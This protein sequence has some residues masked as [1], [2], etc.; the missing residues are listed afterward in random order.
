MIKCNNCGNEI[1][2]G[3]KFCSKCGNNILEQQEKRGD[4]I[5]SEEKQSVKKCSNC[6]NEIGEGT[7][8]CPKCGSKVTA[9]NNQKQFSEKSQQKTDSNNEAE[10]QY[11]RP[12]KVRF[13]ERWLLVKLFIISYFLNSIV[14]EI[15]A[16]LAEMDYVGAFGEFLVSALLTYWLFR[17]YKNYAG[18]PY[19]LKFGFKDET[20]VSISK[21]IKV[22]EK[23]VDFILTA[24]WIIT[25]I[26]YIG[27]TGFLS[28]TTWV[29]LPAAEVGPWVAVAIL[30][31]EV[32]C[33]I[34]SHRPYQ[35]AVD[36]EVLDDVDKED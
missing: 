8:F 30:L 10:Y 19:M 22:V 6:G 3:T 28:L 29:A 16:A 12:E 21:K 13:S 14:S 4:E 7:L 35:W 17:N 20:I 24:A 2:E 9:D 25:G 5:P 36:R 11:I 1:K 27:D 26:T 23:V 32:D 34:L 33:M 18:N 15:F 31:V